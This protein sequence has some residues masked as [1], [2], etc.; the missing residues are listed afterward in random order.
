[1]GCELAETA[2]REPRLDDGRPHSKTV[3]DPGLSGPASLVNV[4]GSRDRVAPAGTTWRRQTPLRAPA[5]SA[6]DPESLMP[7]ARFTVSLSLR[8]PD[9]PSGRRLCARRERSA[10]RPGDAAILAECR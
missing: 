3:L 7:A 10:P 1:V 4:E 5:D 2:A 9:A 6:G 8:G